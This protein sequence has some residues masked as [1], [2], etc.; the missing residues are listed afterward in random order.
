MVRDFNKASTFDANFSLRDVLTGIERREFFTY[1]GQYII[2]VSYRT[3]RNYA[4]VFLYR[5][6]YNTTLLRGRQLVCLPKAY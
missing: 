6:A 1:K 5:L 4:I 3:K 2:D